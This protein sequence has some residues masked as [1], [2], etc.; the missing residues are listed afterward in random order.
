M[1]NNFKLSALFTDNMVLQRE[2]QVPI[3]GRAV[4]RTRIKVE[5]CGQIYETTAVDGKWTIILSPLEIG[6]PYEMSITADSEKLVLKNILIGDVWLAGGQSNMEWVLQNSLNGF[7]EIPKADYPNIRHY[8]VPKIEYEEIHREAGNEVSSNTVWEICTPETAGMFSAVAF[9]FAKEIN[10]G[11]NM[12]IGIINCNW[13][14]TSASCWMGEEYLSADSDLKSYLDDYNE[15]ICN[16]T[17]EEYVNQRKDYRERQEEYN[18]KYQQFKLEHPE[19]EEHLIP[20]NLDIESP[21]PPPMGPKCFL[22]PSGLYYTMLQKVVPYPMKGV[23]WYQGESDTHKPKL[24]GKL[25][26]KMIENWRKDFNNQNLPFLFIQLPFFGGENPDGEEWA[27]L[28]EQQLNTVRDVSNTGMTVIIDCGEKDDIHP[29]DKKTVGERLALLAEAKIYGCSTEYLGPM[30]ERMDIDENE[31]ILF[32]KHAGDGLKV[33][34]NTLKGFKICGK[35]RDFVEAEAKV[36]GDTVVVYS[37]KVKNPV[38]VS[39]GWA[40][41]TE[42]NLYNNNGLPASPFRTD[43]Y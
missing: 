1:Y 10:K 32:F 22:R 24:Y 31:V 26:S 40:N 4:D 8:A 25:F 20:S 15:A 5:F 9:H 33:K 6:G 23:I 42:T 29:L 43:N 18:R 16:L 35:D 2:C 11:L 41:Y 36:K 3:W 21:W 38:A 37:H 7:E 39:Y 27:F 12:P 34:G 19:V 17:E 30:Y 14:G 13:G 28:R